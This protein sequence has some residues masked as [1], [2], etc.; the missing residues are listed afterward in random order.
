MAQLGGAGLL[1]PFQRDT[2][3]FPPGSSSSESEGEE[4]MLRRVLSPQDP[5][6]TAGESSPVRKSW[7]KRFRKGSEEKAPL[8]I[9]SGDIIRSPPVSPG[10]VGAVSF[11]S[12]SSSNRS[13]SGLPAMAEGA[14]PTT[15][16]PKA[17]AESS[18]SSNQQQI[19]AATSPPLQAAAAAKT[20][21]PPRAA[22]ASLRRTTPPS[23]PRGG[24]Y[25]FLFPYLHRLV[26]ILFFSI[27]FTSKKFRFPVVS[28]GVLLGNL[29][30]ISA[31][32][33]VIFTLYFPEINISIKSFGIPDHPSQI[34]W[35]SLS[36]ADNGRYTNESIAGYQL[37]P[38]LGKDLVR[39][40]IGRTINGTAYPGYCN[41]NAD[42]QYAIHVNWEMDL[43]FRVPPSNKD[44]NIL[45]RDRI[46][47]VHEVEETIYNSSEYKTF[48]HMASGSGICDPLNSLL[49][50]L[51]PRDPKTGRY[52]YDTP[53]GFTP[54]LAASLRS[55]SANLSVALWFTGGEVNFENSSYAEAKLRRSQIRVGLPFPCFKSIYDRKEEQKELVTEYFVS[56]I[57]VLDGL[58]TR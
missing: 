10:V 27:T 15:L 14:S 54:D 34:N 48:C 11:N 22:G 35:D 57:P 12:S 23:K 28:I 1:P 55:L 20:S 56:L 38:S 43:V 47:Y 4:E 13:A 52:I 33:G 41:P 21:Q 17:S 6:E 51:Y 24:C 2:D 9:Q 26:K 25:G 37:P 3:E 7:I 5:S 53:D 19:Q 40:S 42:T 16:S 46:A 31:L 58:S 30:Y 32:F 39:R 18:S 49:T 44:D 36:A 29:I 45:R 8:S 50:W